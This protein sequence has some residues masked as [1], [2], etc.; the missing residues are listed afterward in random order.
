MTFRAEGNKGGDYF[1]IEKIEDGKD[2][3]IV[4]IE[5]GHCCVVYVDIQLPVAV[6]TALIGEYLQHEDDVADLFNKKI[7]W[8]KEYMKELTDQIKPSKKWIG[9]F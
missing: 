9:H 5:I 4:N 2:D 3:D 6:L 7:H 8:S 1:L